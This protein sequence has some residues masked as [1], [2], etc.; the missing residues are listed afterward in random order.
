MLAAGAVLA[1]GALMARAPEARAE[2]WKDE[3]LGYSFNYP[4]R[5]TSI[6]VDSGDWLVAKFNSNREYEIND[7]TERSGWQ[8]HKPF[9]EVV[10]IPFSAKD[11]KGVTVEQ[12]DKEV[13][14]TRAAPWK[15]I[16]EYMDK[17]YQGRQIGGFHFS[18]ENQAEVNGLKVR[19]LEITI[20][21]MINYDRGERRVIGWEFSTDEAYY[22]LI[23]EI[24]VQEEKKLRPDILASFGSFR[25]FARKG[26]LPNSAT[27]GDEVIIKKTGENEPEKEVTPEELKQ[28]RDQ[29]TATA[30]SRI[31][32][33]L[34][35][36]WNV[37]E[38]KNFVAVSH[39][40]AKYTREVITHGEALRA[41]LEQT[42][43]YVGSGYA[44]RVI[45]RIYADNTEYSAAMNAKRRWSWDAP[46]AHTYKDKDGWS[47]WGFQNLNGSIYGIW[48]RDK[49][50]RLSWALPRWLSWGLNDF[51]G[52]AK[53]SGGR[54]EFKADLWERERMGFLK[55]GKDLVP[56]RSF[57]T[58]GSDEF[59]QMEGASTQTQF[60]INYLLIGPGSKHPK[61]K[62]VLSDYIKNLI[63][64]LDSERPP[65]AAKEAE[66]PKDEKEEEAM[67]RTLQDSWRQ[68]ER[69]VL[70]TLME[71]TFGSWS[72]KDWDAFNASF[73][74]SL[75]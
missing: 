74:L 32:E 15:D 25:T 3:K 8:R 26:S 10:V 9:I 29:A 50:D 51:V 46:E 73:R 40:D 64:I 27:T 55:R 42:F 43:P 67:M 66:A 11:N 6:P 70:D 56:V 20:D 68:N 17:T 33:S 1:V 4:Q 23:A 22:G 44:G 13:K 72:D 36:G 65:D 71:K 54:I 69:K 58:M 24:L 28:K 47:D 63:F 14:I 30:L 2:A 34:Q 52:G 59:W 57:F 5:W 41:W 62:N 18:A 49:N 21:K 37:V 75:K 31:K 48:L 61:Y 12:T 38:G 53:S 7:K 16:K 39:C 19:Q 60:F 35:P 45:I